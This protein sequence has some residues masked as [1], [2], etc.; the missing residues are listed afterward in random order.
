MS[1]IKISFWDCVKD[2]RIMTKFG[3]G[4]LVECGECGAFIP[5][6]EKKC[7]KCGAVFETDTARCSEC[8][9]W[10][11]VK[12]KS[13]PECGAE[14]IQ[15][16]GE[17]MYYCSNAACPAQAQHRI[18]HFASRGAMDIR[19]IGENISATLFQEGLVKNVAE[20]YKLEKK[21][22]G[23]LKLEKPNLCSMVMGH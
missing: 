9:G 5:E 17:V 3:L 20:L 21:R 15:P 14:V 6:G 4:K 11:P 19:G 13:C 7:P 18:E 22:E 8:G 2:P 10:I 16:E 23:L 1:E 12:S